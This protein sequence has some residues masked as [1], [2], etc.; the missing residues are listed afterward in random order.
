ML[1]KEDRSRGWRTDQIDGA[2]DS[3]WSKEISYL[4]WKFNRRFCPW[5]NPVSWISV[6]ESAGFHGIKFIS[7]LSVI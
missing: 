1:V 7:K 5:G 2:T 6:E 4:S 3:D